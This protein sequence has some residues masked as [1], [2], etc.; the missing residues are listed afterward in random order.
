MMAPV[1]IRRVFALS[2]LAGLIA[3]GI[4]A[5]LNLALVRPYFSLVADSVLDELIVDGKYDE[6]EFDSKMN[7]AYL[8][9]TWG[10]VGIG[11]AA[12]ALIGGARV[13]GRTPSV[14]ARHVVD[15]MLMAGVAWFVLYVVPVVKYPPSPIAMFDPQAEQVYY[16]LY[17]GYLATSGL[18][19]L[20]IV[21]AFRKL[22][23]KNKIFGT[24]AL[25]LAVVAAAF[26]VFPGYELDS[27]FDQTLLNSW[28]ASISAAVT[29]FWFVAGLICGFLW[30]YGISTVKG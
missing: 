2:V 3:G 6:Q 30:K 26:F 8:N 19:A 14:R 4:L 28:R 24:A 13:I 25:Y 23:V 17:F 20:A 5:A 22:A 9:Q 1:Q 16:P 12:G 27:T 15:A 11:A 29:I 10:S 7:S 18:A 21:S